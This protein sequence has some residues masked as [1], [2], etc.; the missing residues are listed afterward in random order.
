M[1]SLVPALPGYDELVGRPGAPDHSSWRLWGETDT[2]GTLNQLTPETVTRALTHGRDGVVV[3][4]NASVSAF[5]PPLFGREPMVHDVGEF[6]DGRIRDETLSNL[7]TQCS[8]QWDGFRHVRHAAHGFYNNLPESKIS[9]SDWSE[10]GI[11]G[12]GVLLD[13]ERWYEEAGQPILQDT[14]FA[15]GVDDLRGMVDALPQPLEPGDIL[16]LHTG[17]L[18]HRLGQDPDERSGSLRSPGLAPGREMLGYLWDTHCAAVVADNPSLEVWPPGAGVSPDVKAEARRSG[19][20]DPRIFMHYEL[21]ALLGM[22]VGEL[23]DTRALAETARRLDRTTFLLT[24]APMS[25]PNGVAS[26]ANALAIF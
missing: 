26:P 21:I 23:W 14:A 13:A 18:G 12:R 6:N 11:V 19:V 4:L 1:T 7:N 8:S 2:L 10:R 20:D 3:S 17:W 24:S 16:V 9:I 25:I 15:I 5:E 22:A